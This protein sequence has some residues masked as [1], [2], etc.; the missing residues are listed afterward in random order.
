[1][2]DGDIRKYI[3]QFVGNQQFEFTLVIQSQF[4]PSRRVLNVYRLSGNKG[5]DIDKESWKTQRLR[6]IELQLSS[7]HEVESEMSLST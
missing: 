1:M 7:D 5:I 6:K 3:G 4:Y 2:K